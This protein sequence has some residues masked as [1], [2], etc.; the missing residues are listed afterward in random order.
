M[1]NT[2]KLL[3]AFI[4]ASGYDVEKIKTT[5][6][7]VFSV[8]NALFLNRTSRPAITIDYKVTKRISGGIKRTGCGAI[9]DEDIERLLDPSK[10][11]GILRLHE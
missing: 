3:R 6:P 9:I 7:P 1:D 5:H 10:P 8:M 2:E 4:D 11:I